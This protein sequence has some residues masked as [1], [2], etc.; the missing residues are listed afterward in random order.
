MTTL[1]LLDTNAYLRLAKRIK[2]LLGKA[3]GQ[4]NYELTILREVEDEV[5]RSPAL[6]ARFPWFDG[7][8]LASERFARTVRLSAYEKQALAAATSVLRGFVLSDPAHFLHRHRSPP[9]EI[10]CRLLAFG[11]LREVVVVTDDLSMHELAQVFEL[12]VW[13]GH[14]LLK[15]MLGAKFIGN[16]RVRE[17]YEALENN[18]DLPATWRAAK[19]TAFQKIFG[20]E[21]SG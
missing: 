20:P 12:E 1:V 4:K 5:H 19:H 13:H 7:A 17:I 3:F 21:P 15:K 10:D 9:S 14:E 11:Q 2:P 16:D 8:E 18:G 6:S